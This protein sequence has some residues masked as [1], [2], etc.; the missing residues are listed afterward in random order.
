MVRRFNTGTILG[1][2]LITL[3]FLLALPTGV[4][5]YL[6]GILDIHLP[7]PLYLIYRIHYIGA[8]IILFTI[9]S[10]VAYW[11]MNGDRALWVPR[12]RWREHLTGFALELP[13]RLRRMLAS[14]L[15]LDLTKRPQVG[16]FSFYETAFSF[17]TWT[18]ALALITITGLLKAMRYVYPI[19]GPVLYVASTLHVAA[20]GLLILKVL[21][22]LRYTLPRWPLMV[23]MVKGWVRE[24]ALR[25]ALEPAAPP[26][27]AARESPAAP[28][29]ALAGRTEG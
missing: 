21:D 13:G 6:G 12:G 9:A 26:A 20:M 27:T 17:P 22:H 5:Q 10:F 16:R 23:A 14:R 15:R 18:F 3:G 28:A 7:I 8:S 1:H 2:W 19:P 24:N 4:W 11:W 29:P 25:R